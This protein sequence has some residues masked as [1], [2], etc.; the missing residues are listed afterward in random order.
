MSSFSCPRYLCST[1]PGLVYTLFAIP[2]CADAAS[3]VK[4]LFLSQRSRTERAAF[5]V[6]AQSVQLQT[7]A[8]VAALSTLW[9]TQV[10]G[11]AP[12]HVAG[13]PWSVT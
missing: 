7:I 10:Q 2:L 9:G 1:P 11:P 13:P 6:L 8:G 3:V 5:S 4:P 12:A